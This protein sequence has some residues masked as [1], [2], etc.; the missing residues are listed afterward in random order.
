MAPNLDDLITLDEVATKSQISVETMRR[1]HREGR[2]TT[3]RL[4]G[5]R[6]LYVDKRTI[7][8][9][10]LKECG[11]GAKPEVAMTVGDLG[12]EPTVAGLVGDMLKTL[13]EA[14]TYGDLD[15]LVDGS[16]I[17]A[18]DT[19]YRV[20]RYLIKEDGTWCDWLPDAQDHA[21]TWTP[22]LPALIVYRATSGD[23]A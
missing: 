2:I 18:Q 22:G 14:I 21:D 9:E 12:Y 5:K 16:V 7:A 8:A 3:Y 15:Q 11:P 4:G 1:Y 6:R 17:F 13:G 10:L 20:T 23:P 19:E